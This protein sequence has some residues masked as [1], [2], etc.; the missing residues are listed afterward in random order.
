MVNLDQEKFF[1][2]LLFDDLGSKNTQ[3]TLPISPER[4]AIDSK[5]M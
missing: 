3:T 5:L 4:H 1:N 2:L